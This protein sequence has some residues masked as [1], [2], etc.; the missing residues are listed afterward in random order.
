M[1]RC[2]GPRGPPDPENRW[3]QGPRGPTDP[4]ATR[5]LSP[6]PHQ[7]AARRPAQSAES[8]PQLEPRYWTICSKLKKNFQNCNG[9]LLGPPVPSRPWKSLISGPPGPFKPWNRRFWRSGRPRGP[10]NRRCLR[11]GRPCGPQ[12]GPIKILILFQIL[13]KNIFLEK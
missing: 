9:S 5:A 7:M 4:E 1:G 10:W 13:R 6:T 11:S 8:L 3:F 12:Q 2:W